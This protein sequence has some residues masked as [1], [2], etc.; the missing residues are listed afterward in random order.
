MKITCMWRNKAATAAKRPRSS[1]MFTF[2]GIVPETR[3]MQM[4][5]DRYGKVTACIEIDG[6]CICVELKTRTS[7]ACDSIILQRQCASSRKLAYNQR[8]AFVRC[9]RNYSFADVPQ[10]SRGI[11]PKINKG[12]F[13]RASLIKRS[14]FILQA[15]AAALYLT[16]LSVTVG[17]GNLITYFRDCYAMLLLHYKTP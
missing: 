11:R 7:M 3:R 2:S 17:Y 16:R 10:A 5:I 1:S 9:T 8:I 14:E 13:V 6:F 15:G 12:K 4:A